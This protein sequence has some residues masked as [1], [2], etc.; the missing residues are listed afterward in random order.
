VIGSA[1]Q[2]ISS[3][4][5]NIEKVRGKF[6]ASVLLA[7]DNPVNQELGFAMLTDL[8]CKVDI[9]SNGRKAVEAIAQNTYDLVFMDCQMPELDGIEATKA[10]REREAHLGGHV[11]IVALT[12]HAMTGDREQCLAAGMDDY[13]SK[14]FSM[15]KL[16]NTL[17][18]WLMV[19]PAK[20][21]LK[22]S[23]DVASVDAKTVRG[24]LGTAVTE[25]RNMVCPLTPVSDSPID[26]QS[27]DMI[28]GLGGYGNPVVFGKVIYAFLETTPDQLRTLREGIDAGDP[29]MISTTAHGLKSASAMLGALRLSELLKEMEIKGKKNSLENILS[30]M[31][32]IEKEYDNVQTAM[33]LELEK[34]SH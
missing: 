6:E 7:E 15:E 34:F 5:K 21:D 12:A 19:E 9:A 14:P 32:R 24:H 17:E 28:R 25:P 18:C 26:Q 16:Y 8:G 31:T 3:E 2:E 10:I 30:L 23:P 27:L 1:S 20:A 13:L 33:E 4:W 29:N 22:K 11:I